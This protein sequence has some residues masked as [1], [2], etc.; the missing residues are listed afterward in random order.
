MLETYE[1]LLA[2]ALL[3]AALLVS[4]AP[5]RGQ[6][7]CGCLA[8]EMY[9]CAQM[10]ARTHATH[11]RTHARKHARTHARMHFRYTC[12]YVQ[13]VLEHCI[14]LLQRTG[15]DVLGITD[16]MPLA[17]L[18]QPQLRVLDQI[19][20]GCE[21]INFGSAESEL[22]QLH[23]KGASDILADLTA[24]SVYAHA[25]S[26]CLTHAHSQICVCVCVCVYVEPS[27]C[28]HAHHHITRTHLHPYIQGAE[29]ASAETYQTTAPDAALPE[30]PPDKTK[31]ELVMILAQRAANMEANDIIVLPVL[32]WDPSSDDPD[33]VL[34]IDR[35]GYSC[36]NCS[37]LLS[38]R[39]P[40][41]TIGC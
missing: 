21:T 13:P 20:E 8:S 9:A 22:Q 1:A 18:S 24:L 19:S 39:N 11:A 26:A 40:F 34:A 17:E 38:S 32:F 29:A 28:I 3:V 25:S 27:V 16:K 10:H 23:K 2:G 12:V 31:E 15:Q 41:S 14:S 33:E 36:L 37:I 4:C 6:E 30:Q 5:A 7:M 35:L